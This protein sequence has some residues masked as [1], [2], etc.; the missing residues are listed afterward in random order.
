MDMCRVVPGTVF[1]VFFT[2]TDTLI[3]N[4]YMQ[5]V[6]FIKDLKNRSIIQMT[7]IMTENVPLKL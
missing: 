4:R 5:T 1:C 3:I 6:C 7:Y 2:I